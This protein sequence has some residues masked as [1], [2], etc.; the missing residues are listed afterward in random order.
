MKRY[1]KLFLRETLWLN[2]Q[3]ISFILKIV[4]ITGVKCGKELNIHI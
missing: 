1:Y 2:K 4:L 3:T